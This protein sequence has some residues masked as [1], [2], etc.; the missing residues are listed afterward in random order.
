MVIKDLKINMSDELNDEQDILNPEVDET[1]ETNESVDAT[2]PEDK[3]LETALAQKKH[4]RE[5]ALKEA[6]TRKRLEAEVEKLKPKETKEVQPSSPYIT[7]GE[8]EEGILRTSKGYGDDDIQILNVI[9]KGKGVS[10]LQAEQDELFKTHLA[11]K[12]EDDKRAKAQLGTSRGSS[13]SGVKKNPET[14]E[15]HEAM[16]RE[17]LGR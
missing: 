2:L 6:E 3:Q 8:Y 15:E 1:T 16:W 7:K 5:K 4:W 9:S 17:K 10:I 13:S 11:R 12:A 14:R